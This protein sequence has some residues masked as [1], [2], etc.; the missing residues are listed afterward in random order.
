[1]YTPSVLRSALRDA[2]YAFLMRLI[3]YLKKRKK[4]RKNEK[5][6]RRRSYLIPY[7]YAIRH[8]HVFK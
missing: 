8:L 6:G 5:R 4:E 2:P 3:S 7:A 1:L